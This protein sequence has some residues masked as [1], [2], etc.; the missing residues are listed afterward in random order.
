MKIR[1]YRGAARG[2]VR[3]IPTTIAFGSLDLAEPSRIHS[4]EL[5]EPDRLF[6][7]DL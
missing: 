4:P 5:D 6:A 1:R 2:I 3:P 7:I